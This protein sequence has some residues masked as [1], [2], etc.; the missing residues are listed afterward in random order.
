MKQII[1]LFMVLFL[2]TAGRA[3]DKVLEATCVSGTGCTF[4]LLA[5]TGEEMDVVMDTE[6]VYS[7]IGKDDILVQVKTTNGWKTYIERTRTRSELDRL[8]GGDGYTM[9]YLFDPHVQPKDGAWKADM[10]TPVVSPC[11]VD[12]SA[13]ISRMAGVQRAGDIRFPKPFRPEFLL[14]NP[15]MRWVTEV[16]NKFRGVMDFG[17]GAGSPMKMVYQATMVHE[18]LIEGVISATISIP[19]QAPCRFSI[20]VTFT[21]VSES[22]Q[23]QTDPFERDRK[24]QVERLEDSPKTEVRRV[25]EGDELLPITSK[26]KNR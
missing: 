21:L 1:T 17:Q 7:S 12:I 18:G 26:Q 4:R 2:A 10:G 13:Q 5:V 11:V 24:P 16:P 14:N 3:G 20:P 6:N 9:I 25:D 23:E 8:Y 19:S 22:P 15:A